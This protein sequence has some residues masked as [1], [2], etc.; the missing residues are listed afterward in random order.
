ML[1]L[2]LVRPWK[3]SILESYGE[4]LNSGSVILARPSI[5]WQ[6][7]CYCLAA[8]RCRLCPASLGRLC[9]V[10]AFVLGV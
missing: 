2:A 1:F 5:G 8:R 4:F 7:T 3:R 6:F 9:L 10:P